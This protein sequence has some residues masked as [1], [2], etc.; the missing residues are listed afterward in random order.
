M[1]ILP[2]LTLADV[3]EF[4]ALSSGKPSGKSYK[5]VRESVID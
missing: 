4:A 3:H 5:V 1:K 2:S